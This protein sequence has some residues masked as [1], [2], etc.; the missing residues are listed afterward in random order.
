MA[1]LED[2]RAQFCLEIKCPYLNRCD[3]L[4]GHDCSRNNG[5]KIPRIQ[6]RIKHFIVI[7][8]DP[9]GEPEVRKVVDPFFG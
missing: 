9:G 7:S 8:C 1:K 2:E 4:W 3:P 5:N 6:P